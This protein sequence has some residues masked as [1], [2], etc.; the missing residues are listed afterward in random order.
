ME[1]P[2]GWKQEKQQKGMFKITVVKKKILLLY[3]GCL[4]IADFS[5]AVINILHE[6]SHAVSSPMITLES[7]KK[8]FLGVLL[9]EQYLLTSIFLHM[10]TALAVYLGLVSCWMAN[11]W[12]CSYPLCFRDYHSSNQKHP[13]DMIL[14]PPGSWGP[15][16]QGFVW[17]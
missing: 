1:K 2:K 8:Y 14:P 16:V 15:C 9:F 12:F 10:N 11:P 4:K 7:F 13:M 17:C 5:Y 3:N 6:I